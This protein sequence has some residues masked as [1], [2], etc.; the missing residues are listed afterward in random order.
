[1]MKAQD[2]QKQLSPAEEIVDAGQRH[3]AA[4]VDTVNLKQIFC[5]IY[6][7]GRNVHF[8]RSYLL[9]WLPNTSTFAHSD[10]VQSRGVHAI[11]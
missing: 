2:R 3:L 8:G 11:I 5:Q 1:M 10:A 6:T 4:L 9:E 7:N